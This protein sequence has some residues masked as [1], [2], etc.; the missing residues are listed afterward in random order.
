MYNLQL[1]N[2]PNSFPSTLFG[3]NAPN[4]IVSFPITH[5]SMT[6]H[7]IFP[8]RVRISALTNNAVTS[9]GDSLGGLRS[10][11]MILDFLGYTSDLVS[12]KAYKTAAGGWIKIFIN[13]DYF[14][15]GVRIEWKNV[16]T[17]NGAMHYV[18]Q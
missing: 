5:N 11:P 15:K 13:G 9:A 10:K 4:T 7:L 1:F 14:V 17:S 2:L 8:T 12:G 3:T 16:A 18:N 6:C